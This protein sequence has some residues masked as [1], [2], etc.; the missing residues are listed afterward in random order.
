MLW[1]FLEKLVSFRRRSWWL[2]REDWRIERWTDDWDCE[3]GEW[4]DR[5]WCSWMA[6][7]GAR[8]SE[9]GSWWSLFIRARKSFGFGGEFWLSELCL[10][11][12]S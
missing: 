9:F 4:G 6:L 10:L 8:R 5:V 12:N 2:R 11:L 7:R 1:G 3:W